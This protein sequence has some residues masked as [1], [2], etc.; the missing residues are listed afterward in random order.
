MS[1]L[2]FNDSGSD[3][4]FRALTSVGYDAGE[5]PSFL[6]AS[7]ITVSPRAYW[8]SKRCSLEKKLSFKESYSAQQGNAWHKYMEFCLRNVPD[9]VTEKRLYCPFVATN[10]DVVTVSGQFDALDRAKNILYDLKTARDARLRVLIDKPEARGDYIKQLQVNRYLLKYGYYM[11]NGEMVYPNREIKDLRLVFRVSDW[12]SLFNKCVPEPDVEMS[13]MPWSYD[14]IKAMILAKVDE[15]LQYRDVPTDQIPE[16]NEEY[17]WANETS[18][19]VFKLNKNGTMPKRK[20]AMPNTKDFTTKEQA[21]EY[22]TNR[23]FEM[24]KD[25]TPVTFATE[26][27]KGMSKRCANFCNYSKAGLCDWWTKQQQKLLETNEE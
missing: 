27:R 13:I 2:Y 25:G 4:V 9:I 12:E 6:S 10:G 20:T 7:K 26:E 1:I 3:L 8:L 24:H 21:E 18:W 11:H 15:L 17:R 23:K 16:C 19:P 22:I 14:D 5:I